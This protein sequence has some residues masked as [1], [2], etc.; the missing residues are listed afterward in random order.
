M[1][2]KLQEL[3]IIWR[4]LA[5]SGHPTAGGIQ[6]EAEMLLATNAIK[7]FWMG[8]CL[9]GKTKAAIFFRR[10]HWGMILLNYL[11]V[12]LSVMLGVQAGVWW[13]GLDCR[14]LQIT[15]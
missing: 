9:V 11:F 5:N 14:G 1:A 6:A 7:E 13:V 12:A 8:A 2:H 3:T 10:I 15:R 4:W